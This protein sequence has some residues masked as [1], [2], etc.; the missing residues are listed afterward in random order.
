MNGRLTV[1]SGID[2]G[3]GKTAVTGL[4]A[5]S[6]LHRGVRVMTS[7]NSPDRLHRHCRRYCGAPAADGH[8]P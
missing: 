1:V 7:K 6:L 4:L 5:A 2:T 8:P 3:V